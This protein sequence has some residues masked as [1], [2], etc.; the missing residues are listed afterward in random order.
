MAGEHEVLVRIDQL[1]AQEH[2]LRERRS[3]GGQRRA[4]IAAGQDPDDA[5]VRPPDVVEGYQG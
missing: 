2:E 3:R 5:Q 1:V 4:R